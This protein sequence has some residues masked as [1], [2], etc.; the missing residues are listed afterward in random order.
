[1]I[2]VETTSGVKSNP[3]IGKRTLL[4]IGPLPPPIGG[5][6]I[7][8]QEMVDELA[9]NNSIRVALINTSPS[10]DPRKKMTGFNLEKVRRLTFIFFKYIPESR[11]CDSVL[12]FANNLFTFSLVPG[13][14]IWARL[15][16]KP[17]FIKP[18][19]GD[20]D[21]YLGAKRKWFQKFL[22]RVLR[23]ADGILAQTQLLQ[24][25]L[26]KFGCTNTHYLPGCR[27]L[28][29]ITGSQ[30]R[31]M[32]ELRLIFLAHINRDKGPLILLEALRL[33]AKRSNARVIC[34][35]YG[36]IHEEIQQEFIS[37]MKSTPNARYCG[38]AEAGSGSRLIAGYDVLVL[39]TYFICEG[40]PG[41]IIEAMHAGIP[42]IST[43]HRA[44]PELITNGENGIL[45]PIRDS[46]A[47]AGAIKEIALDCTMRNRMGRANFQR[48]QEFRT[49]VVIT[50]M[51]K[52]IYPE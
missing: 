23:A 22:L 19:G 25:T 13:L 40:H 47:L 18:V 2:S 45:V 43:Q 51:L 31:H 1:M 8:V 38:A 46:Q 35:F 36:P 48:G 5:S 30:D 26:G 34:D 14:L 42:V 20:L 41:V 3:R 15:H 11:N 33:F 9:R 50:K 16:H 17:F 29:S 24:A 10:R 4:I 52:I 12:V 21:L 7:T 6:P 37:Q 27:S 49:D 39:P 44:I 28:P 32:D